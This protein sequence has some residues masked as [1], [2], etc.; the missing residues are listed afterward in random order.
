M[1]FYR[2]PE[3]KAYQEK[4]FNSRKSH[5]GVNLHYEGGGDKLQKVQGLYK[6]PVCAKAPVRTILHPSTILATLTSDSVAG[7]CWYPSL[8]RSKAA[9]SHWIGHIHTH[10]FHFQTHF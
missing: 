6:L 8:Q 9:S 7:V 4:L 1:L 5:D 10:A 2:A 3:K